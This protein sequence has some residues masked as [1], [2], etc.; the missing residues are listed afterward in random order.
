M[1]RGSATMLASVCG[2]R[3]H[4]RGILYGLAHFLQ[5]GKTIYFAATSALILV[6]VHI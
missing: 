4:A 1:G 3:R 6:K 2:Y 5:N